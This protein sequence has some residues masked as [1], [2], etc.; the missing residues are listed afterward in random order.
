MW[1]ESSVVQGL[2]ESLEYIKQIS[3]R[4]SSVRFG[5]SADSVAFCKSLQSQQGQLLPS[6]GLQTPELCSR[7]TVA[8][9][10]VCG[11]P[12]KVSLGCTSCARA[13]QAESCCLL[14][15]SL[16]RESTRWGWLPGNRLATGVLCVGQGGVSGRHRV[17]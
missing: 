17:E 12:L 13:T 15:N 1:Y 7:N 9:G 16:H 2:K 4:Q 14:F 6:S 10:R 8:Q 3:P 5:A 11:Q